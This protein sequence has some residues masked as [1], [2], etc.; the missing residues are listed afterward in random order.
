MVA[1]R[2]SAFPLNV[3]A[4]SLFWEIWV[5]FLFGMV[6]FWLGGKRLLLIVTIAAV[7]LAVLVHRAGTADLGWE[8]DAF[9]GGS[10]RACFGFFTGVAV[11]RLRRHLRAPRLP[12][13]LLTLLLVATFMPPRDVVGWEHDLFSQT[14][15]FPALIW[16]GAEVTDDAEMNAASYLLGYMSYAI[17]VLHAPVAAALWTLGRTLFSVELSEYVFQVWRFTSPSWS[18]FPG[19][20]R[21]GSTIPRASGFT[22]DG[23]RRCRAPER[24]PP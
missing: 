1:A 7:L 11:F 3:P 15:L 13:W 23:Y 19:L 16:F 2:R 5:N 20:L 24:R 4:W 14:I 8:W 18:P 6:A 17:Y 21:I 22:G 10:A 9:G 12:S